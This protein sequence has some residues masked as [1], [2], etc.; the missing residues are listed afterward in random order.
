[1]GRVR[2]MI[3]MIKEKR[4]GFVMDETMTGYHEFEEDFGA[5]GKQFMEFRV[6]WGPKDVLHWGN[7]FSSGLINDLAG[8]VT[9][10]GLCVNA[11][12]RG[13]LELRYLKDATIRYT[14]DLHRGRRGLSLCG[15]KDEHHAL[16][17][18]LQP[19]HLFWSSY[20]K[21]KRRTGKH[22]PYPLPLP[23]QPCLCRKSAPRIIAIGT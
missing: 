23:H 20:Q 13:S 6:T 4:F 8:T 17:P 18:A 21:G 5:A 16:E 2:D 12:C 7:P 11:P 19:H 3:S 15:R 1:M 22:Q 10:E 14:F 9:I